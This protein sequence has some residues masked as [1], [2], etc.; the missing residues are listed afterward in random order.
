MNSSHQPSTQVQSPALPRSYWVIWFAILTNKMGSFVVPFLALYLTQKRGMAI[1]DAGL[2][3]SLYGLGCV[4]A[5]SAGGA[6]A[7]RLGRLA[8]I[9][10]GMLSSAVAMVAVGL[11]QST[12]QVIVAVF[13]LGL[14]ND[15]HRPALMALISDLVPAESRLRAFSLAYWANNLGFTMAPI[16]AGLLTK[17]S[18]LALFLGDAATTLVCLGLILWKVPEPQSQG[19]R[20]PAPGWAGLSSPFSDRVFLAFLGITFL[21]AFLFRQMTVA[22]PAAMTARGLSG[23]DYGLAIAVNG[24]LVI[25]LQPFTSR[26]VARYSRPTMLAAA[27]VLAGV[28]FGLNLVAYSLAGYAFAVA[29]WTLGEILMVPFNASIVADLS[30]SD[31]RG[32]YH[33][34]YNM[35]WSFSLL[36]APALGSQI[37][38]RAG[39]EALWTLCAAIGL[40]VAVLQIYVAPSQRKRAAQLQANVASGTA[41]TASPANS[42]INA[43]A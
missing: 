28:G 29:V 6:L 1:G 35:A 41:L 26:W 42:S 8:T 37:L 19:P 11:S 23:R 30:P 31:Q 3:V 10:L 34:A 33:G 27:A 32:R 20:A 4:I 12:M 14:V 17:I 22:L 39:Q 16:I 24:F 25:S 7:D 15:I 43:S 2:V 13:L 9:R 36:T 5:N 18:F 40:V 21:M 38:A